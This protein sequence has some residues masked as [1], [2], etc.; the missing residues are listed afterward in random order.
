[1]NSSTHQ[2]LKT[3]AHYPLLTIVMPC[4][5]VEAYLNRGLES[6]ADKRFEGKLEVLIVNDGSTDETEQIAQSYV[7]AHP[8]IF[9]L[10]TKENGGHG[11]GINTGIREAS[12]L[13]FRILDGDDWVNT[14]NLFAL[15]ERLVDIDSDMIVD[16]MTEV[17]MDSGNERFCELPSFIEVDTEQAFEEI[18]NNEDTESYISIHTLS[19]RTSL[20][21]NFGIEVLEKVFYE[22]YEYIVKT[23]C[24][25]KTVVF[26]RLNIYQYLVGNANQSVAA[27]NFVKRYDQHQRIV[28]ELLDFASR[29]SFSPKI[30]DYLNKKIELIINTHYNI[31]LIFDSDRARGRKRTNEFRRWLQDAHPTFAVATEK[32]YKQALVLHRLGF[33]QRRLD[34]FMGRS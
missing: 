13:Y 18:C 30:Q 19:V 21:R 7:D 9:R 23:T 29:T 10:I 2:S 17:D 15:L 20:L 4:Y 28:S 1:M 8:E 24:Y 32:R 31:L 34:K 22:D 6:L 5:N 12:G 16:E 26:L 3:A 11:S 14:D 25:T 33:D 27:E